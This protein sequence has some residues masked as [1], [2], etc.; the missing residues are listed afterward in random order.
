MVRVSNNA[1]ASNTLSFLPT[2][3]HQP[4][5]TAYSTRRPRTS[6]C[7]SPPLLALDARLDALRPLIMVI[8]GFAVSDAV[9]RYDATRSVYAF[10]LAL[11]QAAQVHDS[12][13]E[14]SQRPTRRRR[15]LST[16]CSTPPDAVWSTF[17]PHAVELEGLG[18]SVALYGLVGHDVVG[19]AFGEL[20]SSSP[21]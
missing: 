14:I 13:L 4:S 17:G 2:S 1:L 7:I 18:T 11:S 3:I 16:T 21:K 15:R 8:V 6:L 19:P 5:C 9:R 12:Y 10:W 20:H